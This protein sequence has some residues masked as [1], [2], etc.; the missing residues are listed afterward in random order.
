MIGRMVAHYRILERIGG[1]GMGV[2]YKAEDTKLKRIVAL[3]FLPS[4]LIRDESAKFRFVQEAQ[5]ASA[6]DHQNIC[7]VHDIN[8]ADD[9][10]LY[11]CMAFCSGESLKDRLERGTVPVD[12]AVEIFR[13][14][15]RGLGR[16]H[17]A[18][19]VHRDVKPAN[20]MLTDRGEAKLVDFG[21]AKLTSSSTLTASGT[22]LGTVAYMSPEQARGEAVDPRADLW[23][24]G[25]VLYEMLTGK[26]PYRG[27]YTHSL[28]YSILNE[29]PVDITEYR[30]D[31]PDPVVSTLRR[32]LS[33]ERKDRPQSVYALLDIM[34]G[35]SGRS[36]HKMTFLE[37]RG[38]PMRTLIV[39]FAAALLLAAAVTV[40]RVYHSD[41]PPPPVT[42]SAPSEENPI[43]LGVLSFQELAL[44]KDQ[45]DLPVMVQTL[46]V[47]ELAGV[48]ELRVVD[49]L[50][51]NNYVQNYTG[52]DPSKRG[53]AC[54]QAVREL[55][56]SKLIDG[57]I[58]KSGQRLLIKA[59]V[60]DTGTSE[61]LFTQES[62]IAKPDDI[63]DGVHKLAGEIL[64]AFE[65]RDL[66][67]HMDRNIK[68]MLKSG[69]T[70]VAALQAFVQ[71]GQ[72][73]L[74]GN[75]M[76]EKY[77]R[78]AIEED[79]KFIA[80]R[81]WLIPRLVER[82]QR[83]EAEKM[84][85]ELLQLE[86]GANSAEQLMIDYADNV[87]KG[88]LTQ[89][90]RCL[91]MALEE[92]PGNNILLYIKARLQN[93]MG[94]FK[95]SAETLDEC[96]RMKWRF[97]AVYGM[98]GVNYIGLGQYEKARA[99]LLESLDYPPPHFETY[100][101]LAALARKAGEHQEAQQY[102]EKFINAIHDRGIPPAEGYQRMAL[103]YAEFGEKNAAAACFEKSDQLAPATIQYIVN[104]A[105]F[106]QKNGDFHDAQQK[107]QQCLEIDAAN[108]EASLGLG[109]LYDREKDF[110][111][112]IHFY[113][114]FLKSEPRSPRADEVRLRLQQ[115]K[116]RG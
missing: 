44:P 64:N 76:S 87:I 20:I 67:A 15:A 7:T 35:G 55:G 104:W 25:V 24:L 6:L 34:D 28:L 40:W 106:L 49:P 86:P 90:L 54:N 13:Q 77:L 37:H 112:A 11:I 89:Q 71:A 2:V 79:P 115:L 36:T 80:P 8:E 93:N 65:V 92:S 42:Q 105:R 81:V 98:Q 100:C 116:G 74:N 10:R 68:P 16:A 45:S 109:Q 12:E 56:I 22:T 62:T 52:L 21:L 33:R 97:S 30:D 48:K 69:S 108:A 113:T 9:G 58:V 31:L 3:K 84:Y 70:N 32:C 61:V 95:A 83:A 96:I 47:Q 111:K 88:N 110:P 18:G 23:S 57:T 14:V 101:W 102:E 1:G 66:I 82:G 75:P 107:Y 73:S 91:N 103:I 4:E 99:F 26:L 46:L 114:R 38:F 85:K 39:L 17:E 78:Q 50:S 53:K 19:I 29:E 5:A 60:I 43:R 41:T 72:Y 27:Q 94:D 59:H 63:L 51:L